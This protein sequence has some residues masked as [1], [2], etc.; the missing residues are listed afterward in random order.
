MSDK[1]R[2]VLSEEDLAG[3]SGG[4]DYQQDYANMMEQYQKPWE[5]EAEKKKEAERQAH[6]MFLRQMKEREEYLK[7][8]RGW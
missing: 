7:K 4:Y 3:V 5:E 8:I 2:F 1:S 6:E